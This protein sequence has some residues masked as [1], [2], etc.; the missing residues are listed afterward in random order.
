MYGRCAAVLIV[1]ALPAFAA[2]DEGDDLTRIPDLVKAL[3]DANPK[4]RGAAAEELGKFGLEAKPAVGP[5]VKMLKDGELY[6]TTIRSTIRNYDVATYALIDIGSESVAELRHALD[7]IDPGVRSRAAQALGRIGSKARQALPLLRKRCADSVSSVRHRAVQSLGQITPHTEDSLRVLLDRLR[8]D[9]PSIRKEAALAIREFRPLGEQAVPGLIEQLAHPDPEVRGRVAQTL[10]TLACSPDKVIPALIAAM[11]DDGKYTPH[12]FV[13]VSD[14]RVAG[15]AACALT[16]FDA[17]TESALPMLQPV[18]EAAAEKGDMEVARFGPSLLRTESAI[19]PFV[20]KLIKAAGR[21]GTKLWDRIDMMKAFGDFGSNAMAAVPLLRKTMDGPPDAEDKES[22][23]QVVA[24]C[25]LVR[26][27]LD[28][29]AKAWRRIEQELERIPS[30]ERTVDPNAIWIFNTLD[31]LGPRAKPALSRLLAIHARDIEDGSHRSMLAAVFGGMGSNTRE[32]APALVRQLDDDPFGGDQETAKALLALGPDVIP[33]L[34]EGLEDTSDPDRRWPAI[35]KVLGQFER[36]AAD[37]IGPLIRMARSE[38]RAV[39]A[40]AAKALGQIGS[41]PATVVPV[42]MD[43]LSDPR[44]TVREQA[45][46]AL[47]AF[48]SEPRAVPAVTAA[49]EDEYIDVRAAAA[50]ALGE[51]GPASRTAVPALKQAL[52]DPSPLVRDAV[53]ETLAKLQ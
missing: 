6:R 11:Q 29:N 28:G 25:A 43:L 19:R 12:S 10:G 20:A 48:K 26:I 16:F 33:A 18:L 49:L 21:P 13:M 9:D 3:A 39:R 4:V 23:L 38:Q 8:N 17:A 1:W 47:G 30:P 45:A 53:K 36:R 2:A 44:A 42:L 32:A 34:L 37:A 7:D 52:S 14:F 24:A 22:T 5:L 35:I 27:D 51:L 15:D 46:C 31:E 41:S 40:A 50:I